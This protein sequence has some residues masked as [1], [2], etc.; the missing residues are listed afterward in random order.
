MDALNLVLNETPWTRLLYF[1]AGSCLAYV[2]WR[3]EQDRKEQWQ[4]RAREFARMIQEVPSFPPCITFCTLLFPFFIL[5]NIVGSM[6]NAPPPPD[7]KT[8]T[9][10]QSPDKPIRYS[11]LQPFA[12]HSTPLYP[13]S[14]ATALGSSRLTAAACAAHT[15]SAFSSALK[16]QVTSYLYLYHCMCLLFN[17]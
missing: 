10:G 16:R 2:L 6:P 5:S 12:S 11:T 15:L 1:T 13:Y 9:R 8:F 4:T 17:Y 3:L 14:H 7:T